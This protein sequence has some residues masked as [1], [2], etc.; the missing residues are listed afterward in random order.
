MRYFL[1]PILG[2]FDEVGGSA[3]RYLSCGSCGNSTRDQISTLVLSWDGEGSTRF[4]TTMDGVLVVD[5]ELAMTL[6][7][8]S[9][10]HQLREA[11]LENAEGSWFQV[12]PKGC[13]ELAPS[14]LR[15][16]RES[17][18]VCEGTARV[19]FQSYPPLKV[20][21]SMRDLPQI[22]RICG[23]ASMMVFSEEVFNALKE[24][25]SSFEAAEVVIES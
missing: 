11:E 8:L 18:P 22:A 9:K 14:S 1:M 6:A 2:G 7:T 23:A 24:A 3:F 10:D 19:Q 12:V 21:S 17:C 15:S 4:D 16:P 20:R 13:V 25:D 5:Q